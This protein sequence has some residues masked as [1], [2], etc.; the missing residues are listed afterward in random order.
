MTIMVLT[1]NEKT[2][3]LTILQQHL[4]QGVHAFLFGSRVDGSAKKT[5]DLDILV[6]GGSEIDLRT[7]ALLRDAFEESDLPFNVDLLDFHALT[8]K[9]YANIKDGLV[10][11]V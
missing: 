11:V 7:M 9:M 3:V 5:S 1:P 2:I 6:K 10:R 8:E 4:P